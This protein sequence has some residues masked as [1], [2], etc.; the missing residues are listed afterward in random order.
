MIINFQRSWAKHVP[1][2][3]NG[4]TME[5]VENIKFLGVQILQDLSWSKITSGITKG[6][7]QRLHFPR[8]LKQASLPTSILRTF[9]KCV[10]E[11][12][13]TYCINMAFQLQYVRQKS[14]AEDSLREPKGS[15]EFHQPLQTLSK[16]VM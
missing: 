11:S 10:V 16:Q 9:D 5:R 8:K 14:P 12:I 15:L 4:R 2:S 6:D 3:I 13:L 7:Q 1:L